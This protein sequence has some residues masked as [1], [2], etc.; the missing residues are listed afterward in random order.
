VEAAFQFV[1]LPQENPPPPG[2]NRQSLVLA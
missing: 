2:D 1:E